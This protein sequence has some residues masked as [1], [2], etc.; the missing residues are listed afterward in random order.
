A[1]TVLIVGCSHPTIE[2][3]VKATVSII[4]APVH[5]L[6]GG[7]HLLP[8]SDAQTRRIG[9]ALRDDWNVQWLAPDHC[10]GEPAFEI[11]RKQFGG[12]YLYAGLGRTITLGPRPASLSYRTSRQTRPAIP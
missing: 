11:L 6:I 9:A 12:R 10:T 3:I 5:L 1:G 7:L 2:A 4:D 8:A